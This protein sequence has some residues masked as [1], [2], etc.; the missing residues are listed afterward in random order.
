MATI[1]KLPTGKWQENVV[2]WERL[3]IEAIC[4][5]PIGDELLA[6]LTPALLI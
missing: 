2:R 1:R 4:R 3:R 5:E 6:N